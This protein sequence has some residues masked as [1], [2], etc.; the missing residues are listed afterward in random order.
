MRRREFIAGLGGSVALPLAAQAQQ[1]GM[2]IVGYLGSESPERF[3]IRVE[4]FQQ[5]LSAM[6]YDE[7]RSVKIEYRWAG[8]QTD[9]LPALAADLVRRRVHVIDTR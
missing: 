6:G 3:G 8:G 9:R 2:P 4:A 1:A 5:G 7:G